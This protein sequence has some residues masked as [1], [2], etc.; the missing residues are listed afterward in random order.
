MSY[1][2]GI[3]TPVK[4]TT[5]KVST[6]EEIASGVYEKVFIEKWVARV[7]SEGSDG[8]LEYKL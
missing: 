1:M 2:E 8:I 7:K 4:M 5:V 6:G 3:K